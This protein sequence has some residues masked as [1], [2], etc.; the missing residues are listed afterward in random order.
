MLS[1]MHGPR[2]FL[3]QSIPSSISSAS[4]LTDSSSL[5]TILK[6]GDFAN[7]LLRRSLKHLTQ[8]DLLHRCMWAVSRELIDTPELFDRDGGILW[9]KRRSTVSV[10]VVAYVEIEYSQQSS[11][12]C[13]SH[14]KIYFLTLHSEGKGFNPTTHTSHTSMRP[15]PV[16]IFGETYDSSV[17]MRS[18]CDLVYKEMQL[19]T[20][21]AKMERLCDMSTK[22]KIQLPTRSECSTN[23][24]IA[25]AYG[26]DD[27]SIIILSI[28]DCMRSRID[29]EQLSQCVSHVA[30]CV[31]DYL[32]G[33]LMRTVFLRDEGS[34]TATSVDNA[35]SRSGSGSDKTLSR[36]RSRPSDEDSTRAI[37]SRRH[38]SYDSVDDFVIRDDSRAHVL[39]PFDEEKPF[40][41]LWRD[42]LLRPWRSDGNVTK[43][44][45]L[46]IQYSSTR[47]YGVYLMPGETLLSID[48]ITLFGGDLL[49]ADDLEKVASRWAEM[50]DEKRNHRLK[51][52][53]QLADSNYVRRVYKQFR[54]SYAYTISKM[55]RIV[56]D[57]FRLI[58]RWRL[59]DETIPMSH[60]GGLLNHYTPAKRPNCHVVQNVKID[61][62][63][64]PSI[65]LIGECLTNHSSH[66][67]EL[68][69]SYGSKEG[70]RHIIEAVAPWDVFD[71]SMEDVL[72][73]AGIAYCAPASASTAS[74]SMRAAAA[75]ATSVHRIRAWEPGTSPHLQQIREIIQGSSR[76]PP[77]EGVD[78]TTDVDVGEAVT[79]S[80]EDAEGNLI[81]F[82][83]L[84]CTSSS[85][86]AYVLE[87]H[88]ASEYRRRGVGYGLVEAIKKTGLDR[89]IEHLSLTVLNTNS[90]ALGLYYKTGFWMGEDQGLYSLLEWSP[91]PVP[92]AGWREPGA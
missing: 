57:P 20:F 48:V 14:I 22:S 4:V 35:S 89:E 12:F 72:A 50:C 79:L 19:G 16:S 38:V 29:A 60:I 43:N 39:M 42:A 37:R 31:H 59:G 62:C 1:S 71:V 10:C 47:G 6:S 33:V 64:V 55:D 7:A 78:S 44:N 86:S 81:G 69:I 66:P 2:Q 76:A 41:P 21:L 13:P 54:K 65:Q 51:N 40:P 75:S 8:H 52:T 88:V 45:K 68:T 83:M 27:L 58:M 67:M 61:G 87:V 92:T 53:F 36:V 9:T 25:F 80:A 74:H 63:N 18:V 56:V 85:H 17:V 24:W 26:C 82:A 32:Q 5:H 49:A 30:S 77:V 73:D 70:S 46:T 90:P 11:F 23:A 3:M 28:V 91:R 34:E 15:N 84:D